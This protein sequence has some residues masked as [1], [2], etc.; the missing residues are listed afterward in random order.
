MTLPAGRSDAVNEIRCA[1]KNLEE[2][3]WNAR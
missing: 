2:L 1:A 3:R